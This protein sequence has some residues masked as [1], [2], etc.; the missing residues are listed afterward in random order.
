MTASHVGNWKIVVGSVWV[1]CYKALHT[2]HKP[3]VE[4]APVSR[5]SC[6]AWVPCK[7]LKTE[8]WMTL[9]LGTEGSLDC[10]HWAV[11]VW[12]TTMESYHIRRSQIRESLEFT[13]ALGEKTTFKWVM[14]GAWME[15]SFKNNLKGHRGVALQIRMLLLLLRL[16]GV[17]TDKRLWNLKENSSVTV[18]QIELDRSGSNCS[19]RTPVISST[20]LTEIF[21]NIHGF[22]MLGGAP[23]SHTQIFQKK[24][25]RRYK[26]S[27]LSLD[28]RVMLDKS[29]TWAPEDWKLKCWW[30]FCPI[31]S[32][33]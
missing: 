5:V 25:M 28:W 18:W 14:D 8:D 24:S 3:A 16:D 4:A 32:G 9:S 26:F 23:G 30:I 22:F 31:Q 7:V 13:V 19:Y 21:I 17:M 11:L 1:A 2:K 20:F 15:N 29:E 33:S 10:L 12:V 6:T 27:F